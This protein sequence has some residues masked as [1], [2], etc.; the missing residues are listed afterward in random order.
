[1]FSPLAFPTGMILYNLSTSLPPASY[2]SLSPYELYREPLIVVAIADGKELGHGLIGIDEHGDS[3]GV[4]QSENTPP[5]EKELDQMMATLEDMKR[6]YPSAM[7]HQILLFDCSKSTATNIE[8]IIIVPPPET[9]RT[10]TMKTVMCDLTALILAEMTTYA[11]TLQGLQ[12]IASPSTSQDGTSA[13]GHLWPSN[14]PD[15]WAQRELDGSSHGDRSRSES[16]ANGIDRNHIRASMPAQLPSRLNGLGESMSNSRP[17]SPSDGVRTPPTTSEGVSGA[18]EAPDLSTAMSKS[19]AGAA[20]RGQSRDRVSVQGFGPASLSERARNKGKGRIGIIIGALYLQAGRWPDAVRELVEGASTAKANSDH[21]WHAKALENILVCLLMLAWAGMDFQIPQVC[22]PLADRPAST[23]SSNHT[24]SDSTTDVSLSRHAGTANRLV[25]LQNLTNL[26]P[27]LMSVILNLY[28][29][30]ANF[31]GEALPQIAFSESVIR[32][33]KLLTAVHLCAGKLNDDALQHVVLNTSLPKTTRISTISMATMPSRTDIA[34]TLL[35]AFPSSSSETY[36]SIT[37]R[38][39]IL[40]GIAS[41]F[42]SLGLHRKKAFV[43]RELLSTLIP[44]LIQARKVGA[45]EMG[46][47]PAAGLS[48]LDIAGRRPTTRGPG[49]SDGEDKPGIEELLDVLGRVYGTVGSKPTLPKLALMKE[50]AHEQHEDQNTVLSPADSSIEAIVARVL[51]NAALRAFGSLHLKIDILR[52]SINLCEALPDLHGVLRFT[53]DLLR[54]TGSGIAPKSDSSDGST[55]LPREDQIRLANNISRTI[56]AAKQLG[57]QCLEPEYWDDFLVRGVEVIEPASW[58]TPIPHAKSELETAAVVVEAKQAGPFIYNPFLKKPNAGEIEPLLVVGEYS[59]FRVTLQNLYDFQIEIERLSLDSSGVVFT[60][61]QQSIVI[62]PYCT[63]TL[64]VSGKPET[65]GSLQI[66]GCIVKILGCQRRSFPIFSDPWTPQPDTKIKSVGLSAAES[67]PARPVSTASN[68]SPSTRPQ[69]L[70]GPKAAIVGL[71]VIGAQPVVV[72]KS[73]SLPQSAMM[74]LE[75]ETKSFTVTL[76]NLSTTTSVDLLLFSFQ[77][78][79]MI[80]SRDSM[81]NTEILPSEMYEM[82]VRSV[83]RKAFRRLQKEGE[84]DVN[85]APGQAA[86]FEIEVLGKPGLSNGIVQVD[87]AHLGMPKSEVKETLYTRQATLPVTVTVN[88]SVNI[89]GNDLLPFTGDFAWS[90]Q[91]KQRLTDRSTEVQTQQGTRTMS[92]ADQKGNSAFQSLLQRLGSGPH[93]V[94]HCLL[95]LEVRNSWPNPL[96]ISLQVREIISKDQSPGDPWRKA[97]TVHE[98]LQPGHT[99]RLIL[100]LPRIRL[101][102]PHAPIPTLNPA[103]QRQYVVSVSKISPETERTNREIFWYREEVLKHIRGNWTEES[104]SR[105]GDIELRGLKLTSRMVSAL[106]V[107]DLGI[108]MRL[109]AP[110]DDSADVVRQTGRSKFS[111]KIDEF[112]TLK[113]KIHN[114]TQKPIYPLLRLQPSLRNQPH[115]IALDLSKRFVWHG[116]LQ[117]ALPL[118]QPDET[119]EVDLGICVLCSGEFEVGAS[120]EEVRIWKPPPDAATSEGVALADTAA[121]LFGERLLEHTERRIWHAREGCSISARDADADSDG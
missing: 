11:K 83:Q 21:L 109:V 79:T 24:P 50:E 93:G 4:R 70:S 95:L 13:N 76:Q 35:K 37:E 80:S 54:T 108:E 42:S 32:F 18:G 17:A 26:L 64:S 101:K 39:M 61:L 72:V 86:T 44:G 78:N 71:R 3:G 52:S 55:A 10:T 30:A 116:L 117:R 67:S 74:V 49:L 77:D 2:S 65:T 66:T 97:Y 114:R 47:H 98:I 115:N 118:L 110:E 16:P 56:S 5:V 1:M 43:L 46:V 41:V 15:R 75:G 23:K 88:A 51:Q 59:E 28:T 33:A 121:N 85:I 99:S 27:D 40:S 20:W 89:V 36:I 104:T 34:S 31:G 25:S 6:Q 57:M 100:L 96:S 87:Y 7:V 12:S 91:H 112:L 102:N 53:S 60:S 9:S 19:S 94:D 106:K 68:P 48:A 107:E 8:R 119:T 45:A 62:G 38:I 69:S 120:V 111:I 103:N 105:T 82:E 58:K 22:Y 84:L 63:Q 14:P 90:N 81:T 29:R 113:T 73:T 92:Q